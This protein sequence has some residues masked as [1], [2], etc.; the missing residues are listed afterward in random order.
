LRVTRISGARD[1]PGEK[2]AQ[3][4][5]DARDVHG[6]RFQIVDGRLQILE[7]DQGRMA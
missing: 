1:R 2:G 4:V 6:S 3:Q 5:G 7:G